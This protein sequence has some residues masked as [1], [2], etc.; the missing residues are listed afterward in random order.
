M[1]NKEYGNKNMKYRALR[2]AEISY[3]AHDATRMA[4][5]KMGRQD[6]ESV[7][8]MTIKYLKREQL[9]SLGTPRSSKQ[10]YRLYAWAVP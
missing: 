8:C 7:S 1:A 6:R 3:M 2:M 4:V 5:R 9:D 10:N